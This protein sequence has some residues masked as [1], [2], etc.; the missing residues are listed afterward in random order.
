MYTF[1]NV[2]NYHINLII[3]YFPTTDSLLLLFL[4]ISQFKFKIVFHFVIFISWS[5]LLFWKAF[6]EASG[7]IS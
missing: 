5:W 7:K 4:F 2:L 1:K 6:P 3:L